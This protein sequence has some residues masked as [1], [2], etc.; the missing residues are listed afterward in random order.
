M[1][2]VFSAF[3]FCLIMLVAVNLTSAQ[4]L[5]AEEIIA[6]H[7]D[8]IGTADVRAGAKT[9]IA[10]GP[11]TSMFTSKKD[12]TLEGRIVI[13]SDNSK[14][15]LGMNMNSS[16]YR[17]E[18]FAFNGNDVYVGFVDTVG[19]SVFG[20]FVQTNNFVVSEGLLSGV[21]STGWAVGKLATNN[22]KVTAAGIK[23]ID[24]REVYAVEYAKKGGSDLDVVLYFEKGTFRHIKTEYKRMSSAA[25]GARPEQS[26]GFSETRFLFT[27]EFG[28][29]K[30]VSGLTL[31]HS[32]KMIYS[33]TGG[34]G[35]TGIEWNFGLTEFAVNQ[36]FDQTTFDAP[37]K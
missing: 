36:K 12:N 20:N 37:K 32:Y 4:K 30:V 33:V 2:S 25:I 9:L 18:T 14:I 15:F 3:C 31:P 10:V 16:L 13:A 22:A 6:K 11:G 5:K 1:K 23:K 7:L 28:D 27:E 24:G 26:T 19:R 29:F 8:S 17:G 21:L 35:T 34:Q